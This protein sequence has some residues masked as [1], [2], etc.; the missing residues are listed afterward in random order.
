MDK[1]Q[2][3]TEKNS[4]FNFSFNIFINENQK[5]KVWSNQKASVNF[6]TNKKNNKYKWH[7]S[8]KKNKK[9]FL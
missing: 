3:E 7:G 4:N 8:R 9:A 1:N 6:Y 2:W 5:E